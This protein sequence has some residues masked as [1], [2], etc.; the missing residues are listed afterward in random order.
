MCVMLL[1]IAS[2]N[3]YDLKFL[4]LK[5]EV[6]GSPVSA[7]LFLFAAGESSQDLISIVRVYVTFET[8]LSFIED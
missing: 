2:P 4:R 7:I 1:D 3:G 5:L 6:Y 8:T